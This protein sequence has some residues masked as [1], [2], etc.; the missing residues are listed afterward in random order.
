MPDTVQIHTL[1]Q[2]SQQPCEVGIILILHIKNH[3][4]DNLGCLLN[5]SVDINFHLFTF[6][7]PIVEILA[8]VYQKT[9]FYSININ[10]MK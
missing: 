10:L 4:S 6:I 3:F 8:A 5:F 1:I 2:S 7:L 9:Y